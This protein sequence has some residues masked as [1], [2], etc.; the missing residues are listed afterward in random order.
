LADDL[1]RYIHGEPIAARPIGLV[2][3]FVRLCRRN[4]VIASLGAV[5]VA[6]LTLVAVSSIVHSIRTRIYAEREHQART[7]AENYLRMTLDAI[8][9]M[10]S[11]V[12]EE[13]LTNVPQMEPVRKMLLQKALDLHQQLLKAKPAH[14]GLQLEFARAQHRMGDIYEQLGEHEQAKIAYTEAI[15]MGQRLR[16]NSQ[17]NLK[18]QH[19]LAKSHTMLGELF[20]KT[21]PSQANR[22][23]EEA[24][25][26]QTALYRLTPEDADL[27]R[28]LSRTL[29]NQG[30]LF[31]ELAQYTKAEKALNEAIRHLQRLTEE[32]NSSDDVLADLG[33]AQINLGF[34]LRK[35]QH[36][37]REA[38]NAYQD[39]IA[40]LKSLHERDPENRE[41]Q[42]RLSIAAL[43]LGNLLIE[44]RDGV[45][46]QSLQK[47]Q[48]EAVDWTRFANLKLS[49]LCMKFPGI[50]DYW[51]ELANAHNSLANALAGLGQYDE[52]K[53]QFD[54]ADLALEQLA[55]NFPEVPGTEAEYQ[56]RKGMIQGCLGFIEFQ[57]HKDPQSAKPYLE[58][59]IQHQREATRLGPGNPVFFEKLAQHQQY[60]AP[61][62][63]ELGLSSEAEK[64]RQDAET[65][66]AT[67]RTMKSRSEDEGSR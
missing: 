44:D 14:A 53:E 66:R 18:V 61:I 9:E 47:R 63:A 2:E 54:D 10:L 39:A 25:K 51:F 64:M 37:G 42:F 40:N 23:F 1:R 20:R 17:S 33:R 49:D 58:S 5:V 59:A 6:L 32:T 55:R 15:R 4:P 65:S 48:Q 60:F 67:A 28:E 35:Q 50:R 57:I 43:N 62:L 29:N 41:C 21:K 34:L 52:A 3:R 8:D 38:E 31:T 19:Y 22:H 24:L 36:R 16:T 11:E 46:D 12:G 26:L 13:S 30:L 7:E 56:S 45:S 27:R